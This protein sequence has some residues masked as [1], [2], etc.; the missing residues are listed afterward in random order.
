M[1]SSLTGKPIDIEMAKNVL[2]DLI[3]DDERPVLPEYIQ[4]IVTEHFGIK[5]SDMKAKK[6]NKE[7]AIPRQIAMYITNY[8]SFTK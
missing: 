1:Q 8:Q 7:V 2:K 3:E 5:I 6:R 4:K